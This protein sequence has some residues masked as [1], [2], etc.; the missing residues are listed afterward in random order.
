MPIILLCEIYI[1]TFVPA[2]LRHNNSVLA[3]VREPCKLIGA[4][5]MP[6]DFLSR[7]VAVKSVEVKSMLPWGWRNFHT[8][9]SS[10][11][12][13]DSGTLKLET[14]QVLSYYATSQTKAVEKEKSE[15]FKTTHEAFPLS[16]I[17]IIDHPLTWYIFLLNMFDIVD[18][19]GKNCKLSLH[20]NHIQFTVGLKEG[21]YCWSGMPQ[22]LKI[23]GGRG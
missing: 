14:E 2:F 8:C 7:H 13:V 20:G 12:L 15:S 3:R 22:G 11:T 17:E 16:M 10:R 9:K 19:V 1:A 21:H 5:D 4:Q 23:W 6:S 18:F